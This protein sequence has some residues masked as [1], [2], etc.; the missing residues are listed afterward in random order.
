MNHFKNIPIQF[1]RPQAPDESAI[2]QAVLHEIDIIG[3][4]FS[5]PKS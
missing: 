5:Y 3:N 2:V 1:E 4:Y